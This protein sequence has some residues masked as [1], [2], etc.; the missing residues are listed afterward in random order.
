MRNGRHSAIQHWLVSNQISTIQIFLHLFQYL[1]NEFV[2]EWWIKKKKSQF[3]E[4]LLRPFCG[5]AYKSN[6]RGHQ[7]QK[8][9]KLKNWKT[10]DIYMIYNYDVCVCLCVCERLLVAANNWHVVHIAGKVCLRCTLHPPQATSVLFS[11]FFHLAR[12]EA[13][14]VNC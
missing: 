9:T 8:K 7:Q 10:F 5:G 12:D 13:P 6:S 1:L 3:V 4:L 14:E 2:S 11:F